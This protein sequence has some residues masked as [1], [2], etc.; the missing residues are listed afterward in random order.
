MTGPVDHDAVRRRVAELEPELIELRR[1]LHRHPEPSWAEHRTTGALVDR[2]EAAGLH[3]QIPAGG[4][5]VICDIGESGPL[6]AIRADIDALRLPD[7]KTVEYRSEVPGICHACGHDVHTA[8]AL[9]AALA[10]A[11]QLQAAVRPGRVRLIMQPAEESVPGGASFLAEAGAMSGVAAIFA[12]HCDPGLDVGSLGVSAGPITS[13]AD[14]VVI[15][16]K[17][18]GGHTARPQSTADLV[19]IASRVV[20]DLTTGLNRLSDPR[21]GVN[22]T[23]G[24]IHAGDAANVIPNEATI[25]GSLR[26]TGRP[27]WEAARTIIPELLAAIVEPL[28]A[29][30]ELDH[31]IGAPPIVNDGWAVAFVERSGR[32]VVGPAGVGPTRQSTGGEDFSWYLDHAPGAY[33]RLGVR[34]AGAPTVDIH[35]GNFDVDESAIALGARMLAGTALEALAD[36]A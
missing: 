19:F 5:G 1:R 24:S 20:L 35:A 25:L 29:T 31:R 3:P 15:K 7:L 8:A 16:L 11:D 27:S 30:W 10:A 2:L 26:A 21:D 34:A 14:Q 4:T 22:L 28:G 9:G 17:G 6:V 12:L 33:F 13:A 18:A 32:A 36:L 23:F